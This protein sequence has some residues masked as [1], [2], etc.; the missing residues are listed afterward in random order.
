MTDSLFEQFRL[1]HREIDRISISKTALSQSPILIG[2][3]FSSS[4]IRPIP[5]K[6]LT[7]HPVEVLGTE[8]E[9]SPGVFSVDVATSIEVF[10]AGSKSPEFGDNLLCFFVENRWVTQTTGS[11]HLPIRVPTAFCPCNT[12]PAFLVMTSVEPSCMNGILVSDSL[13]F[14][15]TPDV[16]TPLHLGSSCYLGVG[17]HTDPD[18]LDQFR[19]HFAC[20]PGF[21]TLS[22]VFEVSIYGSP[23]RDIVR[24]SWPMPL[25]GNSCLPFLLTNGFVFRGGDATCKVI[26]S[27]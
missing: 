14:G 26:I 13:Q 25:P 24:Y 8:S 17:V 20:Q 2:R 22:R 3:V 18:S 10:L 21:Y 16:F 1:I 23:Y 19:Y 15:A 4:L 27:E 9:G 5:G 12:T 7:V 11:A 6:Y